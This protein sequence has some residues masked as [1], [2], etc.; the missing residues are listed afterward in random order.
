MFFKVK[1]INT[2]FKPTGCERVIS[3]RDHCLLKMTDYLWLQQNLITARPA[4]S[5]TEYNR[6]RFRVHNLRSRT[7][8]PVMGD[9]CSQNSQGPKTTKKDRHTVGKTTFWWLQSLFG[10]RFF[11]WE[12]RQNISTEKPDGGRVVICRIFATSRPVDFLTEQLMFILRMSGNQFRIINLTW[13]YPP[14]HETHYWVL[15]WIAKGGGGT[16]LPEGFGMV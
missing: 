7:K 16:K 2:K 9:I 3:L 6:L 13:V 12:K 14:G 15:V 1:T 11:G 4:G 10:K 8:I 5:K